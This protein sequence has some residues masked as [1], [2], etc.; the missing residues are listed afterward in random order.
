MSKQKKSKILKVVLVIATIC[1]I[2]FV[3][4][5]EFLKLIDNM[6]TDL[7]YQRLGAINN[8]IRLLPLMR[9]LCLN[10]GILL[11]GQGRYMLICCI[12]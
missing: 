11:L 5:F 4:Y 10:M 1:F 9:K 6:V 12:Y 8:Q 2:Y 7:L 3:S